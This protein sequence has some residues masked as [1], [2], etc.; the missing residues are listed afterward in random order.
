MNKQTILI[1]LGLVLGSS[2]LTAQT[3]ALLGDIPTSTALAVPKGERF[4]SIRQ[5]TTSLGAG[6]SILRDEYLSP[7][8]YGGWAIQL[9]SESN[10]LAYTYLEGKALSDYIWANNPRVSNPSWLRQRNL[11]VL[12]GQVTNPAGNAR[13][14][15]LEGQLSGS[16]QYRLYKG[17]GGR[18]YIG[19]GYAALARGLYSSRNG[20][21]P[22]SIDLRADLTLSAT[23]SYTL[24][25]E[26]FPMTF[27][28]S[29]RTALLG[30]KW[31]QEFG[32]SFYELYYVSNALKKR[33]GLTHLGNSFSQELRLSMD[34]PLFDR[35][36]YSLGYRLN[37]QTSKYNELRTKHIDHGVL[38]GLTRYLQQ[39][40][41]RSW[42]DNNKGGL[43]F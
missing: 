10:R 25:S 5:Q 31:G 41:G 37:Y 2:P 4:Y 35:T 43:P 7:L 14:T 11:T 23:Y 40:G 22:A 12:F 30:V 38:L 18:F 6:G 42:R 3:T 17:N 9:N 19:P 28:L 16:M 1:S 34:L 39:H 20:N 27:R 15:R 8:N 32:E 29:S 24:A 21:N 36:V 26:A 13:I 33:L